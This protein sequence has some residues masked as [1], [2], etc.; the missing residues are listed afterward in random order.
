MNKVIIAS[1]Q[2]QM[3]LFESSDAFR[4]EISRFLNMARAKGAQLV[5]F[6]SL[7]GVMAA[8]PRV[9]G[10]SVRLLKQAAERQRSRGSL[11]SR[12]RGAVAG[13]P[14]AQQGA[15]IPKYIV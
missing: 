15:I 1:A 3:R 12:T 5:V 7:V 4:R 6:P 10:F 2:Q 11:W 14:P 13:G 8:S 9:Q